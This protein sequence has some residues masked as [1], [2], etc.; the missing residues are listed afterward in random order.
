MSKLKRFFA[1]A[2]TITATTAVLPFAQAH[3]LVTPT[4]SLTIT[5]YATYHQVCASGNA[6][7]LLY[8][9]GDW[10]LTI[11]GARTVGLPIAQSAS[12]S[13]QTF[14]VCQNVDKNGATQGEYH[15]AFTFA[16]A[17]SD[18]Y[19]KR[20]GYGSWQPVLPDVAVTLPL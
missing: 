3:A 16:G 19:G 13:S 2:A 18:V 20:T 1:L 14:S 9:T 10:E 4:M 5:P 15:V 8:V 17:G 12:S 6:A 11:D 7:D